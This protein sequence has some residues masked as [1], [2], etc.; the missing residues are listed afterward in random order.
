MFGRYKLLIL[1][2]L[3]RAALSVSARCHVYV[4]HVVLRALH[5]EV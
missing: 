5:R 2:V 1:S 3:V 4:N